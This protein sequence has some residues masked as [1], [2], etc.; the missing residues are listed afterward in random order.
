MIL[1]SHEDDYSCLL[2]HEGNE[3]LRRVQITTPK[4]TEIVS[5]VRP[6]ID[7]G[8]HMSARS[9]PVASELPLSRIELCMRTIPATQNLKNICTHTSIS[10]K[11][12]GQVG[13]QQNIGHSRC[14]TNL[15]PTV[16]ICSERKGIR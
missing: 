16:H 10:L 8:Q 4:A 1:R 14:S 13:L 7:V 2:D 11:F 3:T 6:I 5:P 15:V 9:L 12:T